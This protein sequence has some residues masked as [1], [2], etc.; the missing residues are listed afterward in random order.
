MM[1]EFWG[2]VHFFLTF[3]FFNLTFFPMHNLGMAG[4]GRRWA[5]PSVYD[6]LRNLQPL[7]QFISLA[8]FC[9]GVVQIIFII[10]LFYSLARG[11]KAGRN[12]WN[13]NTLEWTVPSPP[14]HGNFEHTPVVYRDP[15]EYS[16]PGVKAD[17]IPQN[18]PPDQVEY[19]E[20]RRA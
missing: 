16:V 20:P 18:L 7:N 17:F 3:I 11:K 19:E 12:P 8:A 5:D 9:L 1:S 10:N 14:G 6:H 2:M 13:A 15:Y 4:M